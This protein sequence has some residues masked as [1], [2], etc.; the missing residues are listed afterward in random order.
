MTAEDVQALLKQPDRD[1]LIVDARDPGQYSG[2]GAEARE[3]GIFR[4]RS[5]SRAS[6]SS[7]LGAG[8]CRS[9]RFADELKSTV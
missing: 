8:S 4:V 9:R 1:T 5:M 6:C 2:R 7:R 3:A